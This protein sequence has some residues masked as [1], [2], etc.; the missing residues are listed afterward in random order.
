MTPDEFGRRVRR[1]CAEFRGSV[2]SWGR[3]SRHNAAVHGAADSPHLVWLGA[4]VVLD[5][6][7][8][9]GLRRD[10]ATAL[11]LRL[12]PEAEHDHLQPAGWTP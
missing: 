5:L 6:P 10:Y 7:V 3:T 11:E 8:A 1:Y 12:L 9:F 4:D 2:T